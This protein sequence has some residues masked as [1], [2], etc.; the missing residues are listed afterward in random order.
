MVPAWCPEW[1]LPVVSFGIEMSL[2]YEH[3]FLHHPS[4]FGGI[5]H[6]EWCFS[7]ALTSDTASVFA[8]TSCFLMWHFWGSS[9]SHLLVH[10]GFVFP[11]KP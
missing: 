3:F 5:R 4:L 1:P 6:V 10:L 11:L 7:G 2:V 9:A 8:R